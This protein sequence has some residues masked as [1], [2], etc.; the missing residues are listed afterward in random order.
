M[1]RKRR[2]CQPLQDVH[3]QF[4][5]EEIARLSERARDPNDR[6]RRVARFLIDSLL[7]CWTADGLD[8]EGN[9]VRD[10]IKYDLRHQ[11]HTRDAQTLWKNNG[12]RGTG[13]RHE[14]AVPRKALI[15]HLLS[16][17][18]PLSAEVV[19]RV[20]ERLC[21]A[22]IVTKTQDDALTKNKFEG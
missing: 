5:A 22:V 20:L 16:L 1:G 10:G 6:M 4:I 12:Q 9:S 8:A 3:R 14:H 17:P 19:L 2:L 11:M 15:D 18:A 21:F 7:W 13:L